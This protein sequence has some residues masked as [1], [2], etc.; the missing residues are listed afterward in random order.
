MNSG[1]SQSW[2]NCQFFYSL[3]AILTHS[4]EK[5][6]KRSVIRGERDAGLIDAPPFRIRVIGDTEI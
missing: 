6:G 4:V 3:F 5:A 1:V 2:T